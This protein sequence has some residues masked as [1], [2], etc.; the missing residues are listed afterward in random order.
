MKNQIRW[1]KAD[2]A[3]AAFLALWK[4]GLEELVEA[5]LGAEFA[6]FEQVFGVL[7]AIFA[8]VRVYRATKRKDAGN[9]GDE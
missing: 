1:A 8:A 4:T 5:L 6:L 3:F 7:L 9:D 2:L